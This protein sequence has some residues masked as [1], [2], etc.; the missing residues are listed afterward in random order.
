MIKSSVEFTTSGE[1]PCNED[2]VLTDR[3]RRIFA[4]ADGFGGPVAGKEASR[5]ACEQVRAFLEREAGDQDATM[6]FVLRSYISLLGNVLFNSVLHS[7]R[8]VLRLNRDKTVHE[9]G[10]ASLVTAYLD[11]DLLA[12]ASVGA[13][14]SWLIR[15]GKMIRLTQPRSYERQSDP[16]VSQ[17]TIPLNALGMVEDLEP[18]IVEYRVR[19]GDW[20]VL[21]TGLLENGLKEDLSQLNLAT[22]GHQEA[23]EEVLAAAQGRKCKGNFSISLVMF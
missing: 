1:R 20:L 11:E 15:Q 2:A 9:K 12:I 14:S 21:N 8:K 4:V 7:N 18:E 10:G 16:F 23:S 6:P 13:C 22:S 5:E 19:P 3:E 17:G